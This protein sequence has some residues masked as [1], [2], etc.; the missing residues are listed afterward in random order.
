MN[1]KLVSMLVYICIALI[2]IIIGEWFYAVHAQTQTLTSTTSSETKI[3]HDEMPGIELTRQPEE[4]YVDLVA[5][6]LF[7]KGRKP[8]DEPSPEEAQA[9]NKANTFDW[10]LNGVYSTKKSLSALFSRTKSRV[11]KDNYRKISAGADL[12]GW[13]LKEIHKD[14]AVLSQGNQQKELL[15]RKPKSK[16]LPKIANT[17]KTPNA[18]NIPN[19]PNIPQPEDSPQPAE[20]EFENNDEQF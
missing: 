11:P 10:E 17:P 1:N 3:S 13:K 5:R 2:L 9:T 20:G 4:S 15:L 6:P 7:I 19:T 8:V 14:R 16:E 18:P 12:D